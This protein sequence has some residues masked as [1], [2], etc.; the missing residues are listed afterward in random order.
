MLA[1]IPLSYIRL[2][3]PSPLFI[4][5]YYA[6]LAFIFFTKKNRAY[7]TIVILAALNILVWSHNMGDNGKQLKITFLDVGKGDSALVEFPG[8][9]VML[10]DGG[11][12]GV[13]GLA[14]TGKS[15]AAPYLWNSGI[16]KLDAV[17]VTHFHEDHLGGLLFILENF[18][19]G[20]V[21]DN[22]Q[23]SST[24][25]VLYK[26]YIDVIKNKKIRR[27]IVNDGDEITGFGRVEILILNPPQDAVDMDGNDN[28]LV[29]K[30]TYNDFSALFCGDISSRA[31][32]HIMEYGGLL[33]SDII[34]I[35]HHGG[36]LGDRATAGKFLELVSPQVSVTSTGGRYRFSNVS[37]KTRELVEAIVPENYA[38]KEQGAINIISDGV[39]F[40]R[41]AFRRNN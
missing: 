37:R 17:V 41:E 19:V 22:G 13:E 1:Q 24:D 26:K 9:G 18:R 29:L 20:C 2:A 38:T 5:A 32:V 15:V 7:V 14:D 6:L 30:I 40:K 16:R 3:A 33:K 35:P 39:N 27:I 4:C 36:N 31:M 28:S 12:G 25:R 34:K 21:I 8:A 10:I 11:S 23:P